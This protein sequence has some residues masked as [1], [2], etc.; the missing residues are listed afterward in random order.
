[1]KGKAKKAYRLSE[2]GERMMSWLEEHIDDASLGINLAV[3]K[4]IEEGI[5]EE[6]E[7]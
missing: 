7:E 6:V 3:T 1:M 4:M 5:F 2:K